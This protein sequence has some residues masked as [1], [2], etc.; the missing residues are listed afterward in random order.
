MYM[1]KRVRILMQKCE[2]T[3][4]RQDRIDI[5]ATAKGRR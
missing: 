5:I 3:E 2:A 1:N 4:K